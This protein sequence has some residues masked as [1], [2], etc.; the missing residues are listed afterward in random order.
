MRIQEI[1]I[2]IAILLY[3][4]STINL[5]YRSLIHDEKEDIRMLF[6]KPTQSMETTNVFYYTSLLFLEI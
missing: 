1:F 5:K 4:Y 2:C 6:Q 3:Y